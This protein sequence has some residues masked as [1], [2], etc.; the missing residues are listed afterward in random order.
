M[1]QIWGEG[2]S[3]DTRNEQTVGGRWRQVLSSLV[4]C[5]F[6][7]GIYKPAVAL[8]GLRAAGFDLNEDDL[9]RIGAAVLSAKHTF[10]VRE[11]FSL[12]DIRIPK[13]IFET[14]GLGQA[15]SEPV[16]REAL[17]L[18]AKAMVPQ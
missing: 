15:V 14:P 11:G 4:V 17:D 8:Q 5:F 7:R 13:R 16:I 1:D 9:K 2:Q 18:Y 3:G 12:R 10:K 6:A